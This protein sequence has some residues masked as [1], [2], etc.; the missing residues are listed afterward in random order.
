MVT[1]R[2][3]M[4]RFI[5]GIGAPGYR[6]YSSPMRTGTATVQEFA[7][8]L[9]VFEL[10][11][12]YNT[13]GNVANPFPTF[14][15]YDESRLSAAAS[16]FD[17]GWR[18]PLATDNLVPGRGYSAQTLPTTTVGIT[19]TLQTGAVGLSLSRG[20]LA[21]Q[22]WHLLGNP[23]PAPID[24]DLLPATPGLDRALYVFVPSGTYS[25]AYRSYINGVGQNGGSKDLA[26][27]QGFFVRGVTAGAALSFTDAMRATSY[28]S[29]GFTRS[30]TTA[31]TLP[32][33]RLEARNVGSGLR[34]EAVIYFEQPAGADYVAG[35]DAVKLR[36]N[37]A[38]R[39]TLWSQ[40]GTGSQAEA[41]AING[42]PA[43]ATAGVVPLGVRVSQAGAHRLVLTSLANLPAGTQVVLEDRLLNRRQDLARD[44]SYA[45]TSHPDST[46]QRFYLWL[47]ATAAPLAARPSAAS[48]LLS[49]VYPNPTATGRA[50]LDVSGLAPQAPVSAEVLDAVGRVLL[51]LSLPV[52]QGNISEALDLRGLPSGVYALRLHPVEGTVVKRVVRE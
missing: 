27:M 5:T 50:T 32:L 19:G 30:T 33:L 18:V 12:A 36:L 4:Q 39:P 22:G 15:E 45:F 6:H 13:V 42:L 8:D 21:T 48:A 2:A 47:S 20:P 43:L 52:R 38:G 23:Y 34:D 26:A 9:P 41:L 29:P 10:N 46:R 24:W 49:A 28:L 1:G 14:F 3:A 37:A 17:Q 35:Y 51:R 31:G 44:S 16:F 25:G 7:D 11:P 40:A